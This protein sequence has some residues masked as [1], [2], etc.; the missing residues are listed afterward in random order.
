[1]AESVGMSVTT[2]EALAEAERV[3]AVELIRSRPERACMT[4]LGFQTR[5]RLCSPAVCRP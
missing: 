2:W 4:S 3:R 1:M 5:A